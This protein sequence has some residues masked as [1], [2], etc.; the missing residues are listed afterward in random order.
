MQK[1]VG[2]Y[3]ADMSQQRGIARVPRTGLTRSRRNV[4]INKIISCFISGT[5]VGNS[6]NH[7]PR[8]SSA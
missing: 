6:M 1:Q 3:Y 2:K 5:A 4:V 7:S 8:H